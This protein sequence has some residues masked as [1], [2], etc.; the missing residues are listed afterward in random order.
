MDLNTINIIAS[1]ASL[2]VSVGAVSL[3]I[4]FYMGGRNTEL[5]IS[6][7]L[8]EIKAQTEALQKTFRK[9][10]RQTNETCFRLNKKRT[11]HRNNQPI[12]VNIERHAI[13]PYFTY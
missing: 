1:V 8:A 7:A 6:T 9:T 3:A 12:A 4:I 2:V 10:N 13:R 11:K 5:R